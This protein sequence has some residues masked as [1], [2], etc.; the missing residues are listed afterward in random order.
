MRLDLHDKVSRILY[1]VGSNEPD[2]QRFVKSILRPDWVVMD[3]GAHIGSYTLFMAHLLDP[4]RGRVY[5]I[6]PNPESFATLKYHVEVNH[7]EHVVLSNVGISA[8]SGELDFFL[9]GSDNSSMSSLYRSGD[10]YRPIKVPVRDLEDFTHRT[11]LSRLDFIKMDVE[12]AEP[13]VLEG[14]RRILT[15]YRPQML[16]EVNGPVLA[17][18]RQTPRDLALLLKGLNYQLFRTDRPG[19][20]IQPDELG[21]RDFANIYCKP[22][23]LV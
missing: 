6:E 5:A 15:T 14:G 18:R 2:E 4:M 10:G 19:T 13:D 1:F 23:E 21:P 7:L 20:E 22:R 8:S 12:G 17:R 3:I 11:G 9:A 16:V